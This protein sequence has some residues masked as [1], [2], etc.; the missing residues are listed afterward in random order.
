MLPPKFRPNRSID[1]PVIAFLTFCN[2]AAVRKLEFEFCFVILESGPPTKST[3][4]FDYPV[5]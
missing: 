5:K 1:R 2:M 3:V 4:R